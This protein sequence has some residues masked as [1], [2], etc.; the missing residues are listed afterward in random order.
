M[1]ADVVRLIKIQKISSPAI[2][3]HSMGGK[4]AMTLVQK[5]LAS[6]SKLIVADIAPVRYTHSHEEFVSAMQCVD[7]GQVAS[8]GDVDNQLTKD[9][10][11]SQVR[12]FLLQNLK[13]ESD[14]YSWRINLGA[15]AENMSELL[16][17]RCKEVCNV[18][19]LFVAGAL[20]YYITAT[21][22]STIRHLFPSAYIESISNAGHW[23]H[24]EQPAQ[25][26][27]LVN[28]FLL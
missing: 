10:A 12:Q 3:G 18:E 6:V 4:T 11:N 25:F 16:D 28:S 21:H 13:R 2:L 14:G 24:A 27:E 23:L 20:S 26:V 1:A 17:Y 9:I 7:F 22:H 15:I 5:N 8:R 19:T